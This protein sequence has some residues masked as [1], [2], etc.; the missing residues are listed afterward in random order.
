MSDE[1]ASDPITNI[2]K[3]LTAEDGNNSGGEDAGMI[4]P[5]INSD[6]L[7]N[8]QNG[9]S[10]STLQ[11]PELT[12]APRINHDQPPAQPDQSQSQ[13]Q[14]PE[15]SNVDLII[16][17]V[18][19]SIGLP[20]ISSSPPTSINKG[21]S[22]V[23]KNLKAL[24]IDTSGLFGTSSLD[25]NKTNDR[26][27]FHE[28]MIQ[29]ANF[30]IKDI[31]NDDGM[32]ENLDN[33]EN[34]R[35]E[36]SPT[37]ATGRVSST[38]PISHKCPQCT[39]RSAWRSCVLTHM[40]LKHS[41]QRP[42][43]CNVC[44]KS[45][46]LKHHLKQHM[47]TAHGQTPTPANRIDGGG[48]MS[49]KQREKQKKLEQLLA[50][51]EA[52]SMNMPEELALNSMPSLSLS[53]FEEGNLE[54]E[55]NDDQ[56]I[57]TAN[58]F[59]K[60][61]GTVGATHPGDEDPSALDSNANNSMKRT[62]E[63][64]LK[65]AFP[66]SNNN[67]DGT[68]KESTPLPENC[69]PPHSPK[70]DLLSVINRSHDFEIK[71]ENFL[72]NEEH[73]NLESSGLKIDTAKNS[74]DEDHNGESTTNNSNTQSNNSLI[75][76][77]NPPSLKKRTSPLNQINCQP[78]KKVKLGSPSNLTKMTAKLGQG[79]VSG[80]NSQLI[81]IQNCGPSRSHQQTGNGL[82][83]SIDQGPPTNKMIKINNGHG[84]PL[85]GNTVTNPFAPKITLK[86]ELNG[87]QKFGHGG[88]SHGHGH[89]HGPGPIVLSPL[90]LKKD[91]SG[92]KS[93]QQIDNIT[94]QF[95][96]KSA[97]IRGQ[98]CCKHCL[99]TFPDNILYGLHMG[100][101]CVSEPFKCNIC[102]YQ[103]SDRYDFMFHFAM[104]RHTKQ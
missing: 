64:M 25:L 28:S 48:K 71:Q 81:T 92:Q 35:F 21:G 44:T 16:D 65:M 24:T 12:P 34:M 8:L 77:N 42:W 99:I 20:T 84:N 10:S 40:K 100:Q 39:Y 6:L 61:A 53:M 45:Y 4:K 7:N 94:E 93:Q 56:Y 15:K 1:G 36:T 30:D 103:C 102:S 80:K 82:L 101:H 22:N 18:A 104:G 3:G 97:G 54:N 41:N 13:N 88:H 73:H 57:E 55:N 95:K 98:F 62:L 60:M 70:T 59:L 91:K 26:E 17:S 76:S 74:Y 96:D 67:N 75:I 89:G 90:K 72:G 11:L 23:S 47:E 50:Q 86:S 14:P 2:L 49:K 83:V 29:K 31:V 19:N 87:Q 37:A 68:P 78:L 38:K 63:Q 46:K 69:S 52:F 85:L 58:Q 5:L 51:Q 32:I 66:T 79:M 33:L 9:I 27:K 43:Q